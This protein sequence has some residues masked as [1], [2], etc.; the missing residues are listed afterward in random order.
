MSLLL[1]W[2]FEGQNHNLKLVNPLDRGDVWHINDVQ[3]LG[4]QG[5]LT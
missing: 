2:K 3:K 5:K 1:A 4:N